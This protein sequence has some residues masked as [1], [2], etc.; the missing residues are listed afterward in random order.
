MFAE[1]KWTARYYEGRDCWGVETEEHQICGM[2]AGRAASGLLSNEEHKANANLIA[3]SPRMFKLLGKLVYQDGWMY[4]P[5][6][7]EA[8]EII[9]TIA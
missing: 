8:K 1:G 3:L 6:V 5:D 7:R 4:A 2:E 9:Q